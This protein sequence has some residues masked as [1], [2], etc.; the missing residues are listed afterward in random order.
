MSLRF[1]SSLPAW[2]TY[3]DGEVPIVLVA[4]HGGRRPADAPIRDSLKVN[5]LYTAELTTLLAARTGSYA[6]INHAGDRNDL[7]LNRISQVRT[8]APWFLDALLE[9]LSALVAHHGAVR[10]FFIHGWNVVQ[11][12][13][14]LGTGLKQ[15]GD[16]VVPA[17]KVAAPT[18][19]ASFFTEAILPFRTAALAQGIDVA[20]GRRYPAADKDNVMQVFSARFAEDPFPAIRT[21]AALATQEN[22]NAVQ[23]ELG[24]GLRWPGPER[25]RFIEVFCQ[26]LGKCVP[27]TQEKVRDFPVFSFSSPPAPVT[28]HLNG[29]PFSLPRI[30]EPTRLGLHFHDP[31]SGLG[32]MG[33]IEFSSA[34]P[35]QSGRLM[36]SLGGT[37]MV[38]FTGEDATTIDAGR[39]QVG[40]FVWQSEGDGLAISYHG[41]VMRFSHPQAFI[42]LEEGLA[43][44]WIE[45]AAIVLRL[46]LPGG[47]GMPP[48]PLFLAHLRG[49]VRLRDRRYAI[50]AWGFLDMLKSEETGRLLPR[51]LLSLPF[52]P[53]LGI[54]LSWVDTPAGPRSSGVIYHHGTPHPVRPEDWELRYTFA[55]GRPTAFHLS[56]TPPHP[57]TLQCS[58]ETVTAIP[59]VRHAPQGSALFVTF[60]LSRTLWQGR[61]ARGVYEFSERRKP[62]G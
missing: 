51:R 9:L 40:G 37:E 38:L 26:T 48:L 1:L 25:E 62:E 32:V 53:D 20:L 16:R 29:S 58:G 7:D 19:S 43:A 28:V 39:V 22:L 57:L 55:Q 4:P 11:P 14:D 13:C 47:F 23:L 8:R 5:D 41:P 15:K 18:L 6:L 33:G 45:S 54:F 21:L 24:V 12:V 10:V 50:D 35:T 59:I 49:E 3:C 2:M 34:A 44:S 31:V 36:L 60:G 52:G 30:P 56:L 17:S 46:T 42:R 61:E 27:L